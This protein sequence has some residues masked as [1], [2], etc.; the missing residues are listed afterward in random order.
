MAWR[1]AK[2]LETLRSQVNTAAPRR[3]K[4]SDGTIG[5]QAHAARVS[6]HNPNRAGV[7]QALDLTH[8]PAGGFDSYK[9]AETLRQNKDPRVKY[10]ISNGRIFSSI[11][12]P[13]VWRS[14]SGSNPHSAHVHVSVSDKPA[15]YDD[16]APWRIASGAIQAQPAPTQPRLLGITATV[17]GGPGDENDSAYAPYKR[18]DPDKPGVALPA[19]FQ[20]TRP[21]VRVINGAKSVVCEIVDVGPWN[22]D[23][24]YWET[25]KRPQAETGVDRRGRTTNFAGI[26][27]TPAAARAVGI[28]G[29]GRVDW[30]FVQ[31]SVNP[32]PMPNI[33]KKPL[34]FSGLF[35][36]IVGFFGWIEAHPWL[37]IGGAAA[38]AIAIIGGIELWKRRKG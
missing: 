38:I 20:G 35:G 26:D 2:S 19:R 11:T 14:Y 30:E 25:G 8:D 31:G 15:L 18:V 33:V 3:K 9:F 37:A 13:W 10:V 5:D 27:L 21:K 32:P 4:T 28:N 1:L 23:D 36:F 34:I 29:K 22:I 17:F 7:V 24:P 6:D 16:T 12:Q